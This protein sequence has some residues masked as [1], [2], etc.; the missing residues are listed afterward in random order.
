MN[1]L[2]L[3]EIFEYLIMILDFILDTIDKIIKTDTIEI[4]IS[5][6]LIKYF[7]IPIQSLNNLFIVIKIFIFLFLICLPKIV[8]SIIKKIK[9]KRRRRWAKN[10]LTMIF[11][12]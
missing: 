11:K 9:S 12:K 6:F 8:K 3:K 1:N 2:N 4:S 10:G 5:D 7:D